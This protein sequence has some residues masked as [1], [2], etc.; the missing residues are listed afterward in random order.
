MDPAGCRSF[1]LQLLRVAAAT[2]IVWIALGYVSNW[3]SLARAEEYAA[4]ETLSRI[5]Y[6]HPQ[7][8][9]VFVL[10]YGFTSSRT[11]LRRA[12]IATRECPQA[13]GPFRCWPWIAIERARWFVPYFVSVRFAFGSTP[14]A[15]EGGEH[16][17]LSLFGHPY[18]LIRGT[19]LTKTIVPGLPY[20][21]GQ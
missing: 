8:D 7:A 20:E 18:G 3:M 5:R 13:P 1:S 2:V 16:L 19:A 14:H 15:G 9:T 17:L 4:H 12:G 21:P 11:I 10:S 6:T